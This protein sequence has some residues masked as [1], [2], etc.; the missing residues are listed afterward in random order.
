MLLLHHLV[1]YFARTFFYNRR[2]IAA[3]GVREHLYILWYF[4]AEVLWYRGRQAFWSSMYLVLIYT[5]MLVCLWMEVLTLAFKLAL[6]NSMCARYAM[7]C[8]VSNYLWLRFVGPLP[9]GL[10]PHNYFSVVKL[11]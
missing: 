10:S 8:W 6:R 9:P 1:V 4:T 2:T 7:G 11:N 3:I 5:Y